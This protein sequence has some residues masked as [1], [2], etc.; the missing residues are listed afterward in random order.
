MERN[1]RH[2]QRKN[3][4]LMNRTSPSPSPR[5]TTC[6]QRNA[7]QLML[8][9]VSQPKT[10]TT[11]RPRKHEKRSVKMWKKRK[12]SEPALTKATKKP[13]NTKRISQFHIALQY[14]N[15]IFNAV[16]SIAF[17]FIQHVKIKFA[18]KHLDLH[19]Y[20]PQIQYLTIT[21]NIC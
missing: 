20:L 17:L 19:L 6:Q 21:T 2:P 18:Q 4:H 15:P 9:S 5:E 10:H 8:G 7:M 14:C 12:R 13:K 11:W 1:S 16:N 3:E